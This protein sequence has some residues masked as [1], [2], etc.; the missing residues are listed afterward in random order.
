M[1]GVTNTGYGRRGRSGRAARRRRTAPPVV[2]PLYDNTRESDSGTV[3]NK[4]KPFLT[5]AQ[6]YQ[7]ARKRGVS[8]QACA[9]APQPR[10]VA[11]P[12][13]A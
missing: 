6:G 11:R 1:A 8:R 2:F 4:G 3:T 10:G 12:V 5:M 13:D 7:I 9:P